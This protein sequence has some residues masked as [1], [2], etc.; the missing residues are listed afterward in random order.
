MR[1]EARILA[2]IALAI[3]LILLPVDAADTGG[4]DQIIYISSYGPSYIWNQEIETGIE[5]AIADSDHTRVQ[6]SI[7]YI[8][9]KVIND[10]THFENLYQTF[11]HKYENASPNVII[12]SDDIA[13]LFMGEYGNQLFPGVPVVFTGVR[14]LHSI[15]ERWKYYL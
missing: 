8:D 4:H 12:T 1:S 14:G 13:L 11:A 5:A 2:A 3:F 9:G 7:E 10:P 6:L 15:S